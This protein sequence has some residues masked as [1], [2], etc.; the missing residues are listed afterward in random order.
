MLLRQ[1]L[2]DSIDG[3]ACNAEERVEGAVRLDLDVFG[4]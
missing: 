1:R 3:S 4:V 2:D